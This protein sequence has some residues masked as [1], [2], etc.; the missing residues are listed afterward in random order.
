MDDEKK[1][2]KNRIDN[3]WS[4]LVK[5]DIEIM[6]AATNIDDNNDSKVPFKLLTW[7]GSISKYTPQKPIKEK[8]IFLNVIFS[9]KQRYEK[10]I[11]KKTFVKLKAV[12]WASGKKVNAE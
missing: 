4:F 3:V 8:K 6:P 7:L 9:L 2:W 10:N 12:A 1:E 5:K 11:T